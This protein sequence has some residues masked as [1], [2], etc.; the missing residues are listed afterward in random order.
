[1]LT[2]S[3]ASSRNRTISSNHCSFERIIF[4]PIDVLW[5]PTN[6][7][8]AWLSF[9]PPLILIHRCSMP[10]ARKALPSGTFGMELARLK[11]YSPWLADRPASLKAASHAKE[12][13]ARFLQSRKVRLLPRLLSKWR[14]T[15][16]P[17]C[18]RLRPV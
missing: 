7:C 12:T 18:L 5:L 11:D 1:M 3:G 14:G 4:L 8:G 17:H 2:K 13:T 9:C 10:I 16:F 15:R 6:L